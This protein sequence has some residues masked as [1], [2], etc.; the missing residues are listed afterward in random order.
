MSANKHR[1]RKKKSDEWEAGKEIAEPPAKRPKKAG[2]DMAKVPESLLREG[3]NDMAVEAE[4]KVPASL[5][6]PVCKELFV[7]PQMLHC[8]HTMCAPCAD[9]STL[10]SG[11]CPVCKERTAYMKPITNFHLMQ[12][13]EEQF[14]QEYKKRNE[15]LLELQTLKKK[16]EQYKDSQ[17]FEDLYKIMKDLMEENH[18][19]SHRNIIN[20]LKAAKIGGSAVKDEEAMYF[21]YCCLTFCYSSY[22]LLSGEYI[23]RRTDTTRMLEW[24]EK[25][26]KTKQ[27]KELKKWLPVLIQ[28]SKGHSEWNLTERIAKLAGVDMGKN[29]SVADFKNH[30]A[31]WIKDLEVGSIRPHYDQHNYLHHHDYFDRYGGFPGGRIDD[32]DEFDSDDDDDESGSYYSSDGF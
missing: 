31:F 26:K 10:V 12:F 29:M 18:F 3:F 24:Y 14:P 27:Q 6:C 7:Q 9:D 23:F 5:T 32:S 17:R 15:Q 21:L 11:C 28:N 8:G 22:F 16:L 25:Q 13:I 19:M 30:S 1:G 4:K 2:I 20:Q